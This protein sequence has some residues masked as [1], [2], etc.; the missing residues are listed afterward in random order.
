MTHV[1]P[2]GGGRAQTTIHPP[3]GI[4]RLPS[5]PQYERP[6]KSTQVTNDPARS[7][8]MAE[9]KHYFK[10]IISCLALSI[11]AVES[12]KIM[13]SP[14]TRDYILAA[15][16]VSPVI[17]HPSDLQKRLVLLRP[18]REEELSS[19]ARAFITEIGGELVS[20][21]LQI[22]YDYYG[23]DQILASLLPAELDSGTPTSFTIIGHIAH[24]NLR[25]EFLPYRFLIGDVILEKNTRAIRTVVNKL[26]SIDAQFRFFEMELL[27][28]APEFETIAVYFNSRLHAEHARISQLEFGPSDVVVDVMAGV[29]P[30]AIPAAKKERGSPQNRV[31]AAHAVSGGPGALTGTR[32]KLQHTD[33]QAAS[34]SDRSLQGPCW[35]LANDLNPASIAS[36]AY[37]VVANK[38]SERVF[39]PTRAVVRAQDAKGKGKFVDTE[40]AGD[41]DEDGLNPQ[42][43]L[44]LDGREF[45]RRATRWVWD[46][47]PFPKGP[48]TKAQGHATGAQT[49]SGSS[50]KPSGSVVG[51]ALLQGP[52]PDTRPPQQGKAAAAPPSKLS[53]KKVPPPAM[54]PPARIP[55]HYVMNL[56]A[57]AIEFLDAYRGLFSRLFDDEERQAAE[58]LLSSQARK[59]PGLQYPMVHVHCFT[60]ALESPYE[61]IVA[62][63]NTS[64]GFSAEQGI[65]VPQ[66]HERPPS[67]AQTQGTTKSAEAKKG[68]VPP[69]SSIPPVTGD[70]VP[71]SEEDVRKG[72]EVKIHFVRR[73][74]PNK[75]M[76]CLSFRLWPECVWE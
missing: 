45:I 26:D 42:D 44:G 60:K 8:R 13:S 15:R 55:Q 32:E 37:N 24:L 30:F 19:E 56:P 3:T 17:S 62:R 53:K 9:Y 50:S 36:L 7:I 52:K 6:T 25:D 70:S 47:I 51:M 39:V 4:P 11:P 76:Y 59:R 73:V 16:S 38:V 68:S 46:G 28:G 21:N 54:K 35:V 71:P 57:S 75:D 41:V 20:H 5:F 66:Y 29:G 14:E 43:P 67:L 49:T 72:R 2:K 69:I 48:S 27:A 12:N 61:D 23:A 10:Q 34:G 58:G 18:Q 33:E 64:L 65:P 31:A 40:S 22:E 63:A 74:A 1:K